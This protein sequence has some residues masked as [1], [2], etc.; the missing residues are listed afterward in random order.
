[1]REF[2]LILDNLD[3]L[4]DLS[5]RFVMRAVRR[6][7]ALRSSVA[8]HTGANRL[9]GDRAPV[10]LSLRAFATGAVI[11]HFTRTLKQVPDVDFRLP[12]PG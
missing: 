3:G 12:T 1:M 9:V 11:Q 6:A 4:D 7:L 10:D 2:G 5:D 8:R